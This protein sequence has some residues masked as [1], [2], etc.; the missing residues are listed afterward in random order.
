MK[1]ASLL[2]F[3]FTLYLGCAWSP[4]RDNPIDPRSTS[5]VA[6][7]PPVQRNRPPVI[8]TVFIR[9]DCHNYGATEFCSFE[10]HC[11]ISD[12]DQNLLFDS[13]TAEIR[14]DGDWTDIGRLS[15]DVFQGRFVAIRGQN[16]FEDGSL[17]TLSNQN[18]RVHAIDDS[19]AVD[20]YS[21]LFP[22]VNP[23]Y[24]TIVHPDI[25]IPATSRH[26]QLGWHPWDASSDDYSY[27]I[28]VY[29]LNIYS[30]WDTSGLQATDTSVVVSTRLESSAE[31]A[32]LYYY[33]YLSI[34]D[35]NGSRITYFPGVFQVYPDSVIG[36]LKSKDYI[37]P[38]RL[39]EVRR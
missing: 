34:T 13:V 32:N 27:S 15:Y 29:Y 10:L 19:G 16:E 2:L 12:S 37:L 36:G 6:P 9:T 20:T 24:G 4:D 23:N 31:D 30:V 39:A 17:R 18:V 11:Q 8:D 22:A 14:I 21:L 33:W 1:T 3:I 7:P 28:S 38:P 5:Y 35:R 26:P 25:R